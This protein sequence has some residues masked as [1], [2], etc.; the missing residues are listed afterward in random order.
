M[1][2]LPLWVV[3][4]L[5][6]WPGGSLSGQPNSPMAHCIYGVPACYTSR[7]L[8]YADFTISLRTKTESNRPD[9]LAPWVVYAFQVHDPEQHIGGDVIF[10]SEERANARRFD[11][12]GKIYVAE[13]FHSTAESSPEIESPGRIPDSEIVIWDEAAAAMHNPKLHKIWETERV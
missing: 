6:C 7:I 8:K 3:L 9:D 4:N 13:M 2:F 11:V 12:G 10:N 5:I 1:K